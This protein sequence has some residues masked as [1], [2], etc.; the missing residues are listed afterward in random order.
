MWQRKQTL[1]FLAAIVLLSASILG[2]YFSIQAIKI[3]DFSEGP[4]ISKDSM[5]DKFIQETISIQ[6]ENFNKYVLHFVVQII[7][8]VLILVCLFSFKNLKKQLA[9]SN[10]VCYLLI[11]NVLFIQY[12]FS[13]YS[14]GFNLSCNGYDY[15]MS[16]FIG[17]KTPWFYCVIGSLIFFLFAWNRVKKDHEL[18]DSL[19]RLR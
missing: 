5:F 13:P 17:Y 16:S 6:Y 14:T 11:A 7:S 15:G 19:N 18:L 2:T 12:E 4:G 3:F 9:L 8:V 10:I 1:F